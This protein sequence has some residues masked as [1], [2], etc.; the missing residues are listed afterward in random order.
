MKPSVLAEIL[1]PALPLMRCPR[2]GASLATDGASLRCAE[3]HCYDLSSRG[4]VNLAPDR[5][6][7]SEKYDAE[8]FESRRAILDDGLYAPVLCALRDM[9]GARFGDAPFTAADIGCG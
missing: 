7:S 6:Q 2:C 1:S 9:L 4:Y 3:G 8:L 5:A